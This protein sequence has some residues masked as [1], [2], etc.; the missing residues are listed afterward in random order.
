MESTRIEDVNRINVLFAKLQPFKVRTMNFEDCVS[1]VSVTHSPR[2]L[3]D[4]DIE[5]EDSIFKKIGIPYDE[6]RLQE[7]PFNCFKEFFREKARQSNTDLWYLADDSL[8]NGVEEYPSLDVKFYSDLTSEER[9]HLTAK[10]LLLFPEVLT[11]TANYKNTSLWLLKMGILNHSLRDMFSASKNVQM[12]G[13]TVPS[14]FMRLH[15]YFDYI[16]DTVLSGETFPIDVQDKYPDLT[17]KDIIEQWKIKIF[18][19]LESYRG[20]KVYP[21]V[22]RVCEKIFKGIK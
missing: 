12:F 6:V 4:F 16:V 8:S 19:H 20:E 13:Y 7:K 9:K 2:Y 18:Y 22:V 5:P 10:A 14:K 1:G 21:G 17:D 15:K 11:K 3:I